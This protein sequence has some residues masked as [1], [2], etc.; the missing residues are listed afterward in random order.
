MCSFFIYMCIYYWRTGC[1]ACFLPAKMLS[2][3]NRR[4]HPWTSCG[5]KSVCLYILLP[6][7][8]PRSECSS[9][10]MKAFACIFLGHL[11]SGVCVGVTFRAWETFDPLRRN[12]LISLWSGKDWK[13]NSRIPRS[14]QLTCSV[15]ASVLAGQSSLASGFTAVSGMLSVGVHLLEIPK[16]ED[17]VQKGLNSA[18]NVPFAST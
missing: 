6:A 8:Q 1:R 16:V 2:V 10:Q 15:S 13:E 7:F 4:L 12:K 11:W 17:S 14:M 3:A 9:S 18:R 5:F